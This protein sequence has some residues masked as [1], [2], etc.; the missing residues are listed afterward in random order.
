MAWSDSFSTPCRSGSGCRPVRAPSDWLQLLQR[1][2]AALYQYQNT[3]LADIQRWSEIPRGTPL[4]ESL[5][6]FENYPAGDPFEAVDRS[7]RIDGVQVLEQT[8]Y[9]L[10]LAVFPGRRLLVRAI[11]DEGRL[12][13][14]GWPGCSGT[15]KTRCRRWSG[16]RDGRSAAIEIVGEAEA[17]QLSA[18]P[19]AAL[20][21]RAVPPPGVR[22]AGGA[23]AGCGWRWSVRGRR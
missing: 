15:S 20:G 12:D 5:L 22:G 19:A 23:D 2:Q 4:F 13:G 21:R 7:L 1:E 9:P 17:A 8:N 11:R 3:P 14:P 16:R 18:G 10:T 6:V